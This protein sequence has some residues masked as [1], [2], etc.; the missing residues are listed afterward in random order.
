MTASGRKD[1]LVMGLPVKAT[2][3]T[4]A[5]PKNSLILLASFGSVENA[6]NAGNEEKINSM[7]G[8]LLGT[9]IRTSA[10][11]SKSTYGGSLRVSNVED[12][13][14]ARH[15]QD[16]I[17]HSWKILQSQLVVAAQTNTRALSC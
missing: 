2:V 10:V 4:G 16:V 9:E 13:L 5:N 7:Y 15:L 17:D 12:L 11:Q 3:A 6:M 8:S 1:S 14:L